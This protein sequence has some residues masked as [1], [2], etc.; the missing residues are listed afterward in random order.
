MLKSLFNLVLPKNCSSCQ[1]PLSLNEELICTA[2]RHQ[3][4]TTGFDFCIENEC[5]RTFYGTSG[6]A[7]AAAL[8]YFDPSG[9]VKQLLHQLKYQDHEFLGCF[10]ADWTAEVLQKDPCLPPI[11]LITCVPLHWRRKAVRGYNQMDLFAQR[12]ASL[13]D[14]N[15]DPSYLKR[16][17]YHRS[18]TKKS[19]LKRRSDKNS[20]ALN[21]STPLYEKHILLVD[22]IITT[23]N[24]LIQCCDALNQN[25]TNKIYLFSIAFRSRFV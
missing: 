2:C 15:Y 7:K 5:D 3:I 8:F 16:R 11:D 1:Y 10:F 17:Y 19:R 22:D 13:M 21:S 6:I 18:Q 9:P 24:S 12:L 25:S 20:F 4:S 23:G 14:W